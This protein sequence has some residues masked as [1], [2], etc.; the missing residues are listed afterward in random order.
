MLSN[1]GSQAACCIL[2][3]SDQYNVYNTLHVCEIC[4][5]VRLSVCP[6]MCLSVC[7]GTCQCPVLGLCRSHS[8]S[9]SGKSR[10]L[11]FL[12]G[13]VLTVIAQQRLVHMLEDVRAGNVPSGQ[14]RG[15]EQDLQRMAD[16]AK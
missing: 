13:A 11:C 7:L 10:W 1:M 5:S 2:S 14:H 12:Q 9:T 3:G 8:N 15:S 4:L 6:P 16:V